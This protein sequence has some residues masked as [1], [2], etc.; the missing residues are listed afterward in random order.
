MCKTHTATQ[1]VT[2]DGPIKSVT[3]VDGLTCANCGAPEVESPES[4]DQPLRFNIRAFRVDDW[5]ECRKCGCWFNLAGDID[6]PK[7]EDRA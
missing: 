2:L 6:L 5:S 1:T 3:I 7:K 4:P